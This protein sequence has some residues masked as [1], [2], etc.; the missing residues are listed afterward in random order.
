MEATPKLRCLSGYSRY[1]ITSGPASGT[2][3][4]RSPNPGALPCFRWGVEKAVPE[5]LRVGNHGFTLRGL[6]RACEAAAG[7]LPERSNTKGRVQN[8]S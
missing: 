4:E 7:R 3:I 8:D 6:A 2:R 5:G 1:E